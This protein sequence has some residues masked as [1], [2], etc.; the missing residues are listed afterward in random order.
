MAKSSNLVLNE[1]IFTA[2]SVRAVL[3]RLLIQSTKS[4]IS[5]HLPFWFSC[6]FVPPWIDEA[7]VASHRS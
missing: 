2:A 7:I 6:L 3:E 4:I 5:C 1:P